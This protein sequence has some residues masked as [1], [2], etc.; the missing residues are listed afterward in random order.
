MYCFISDCLIILLNVVINITVIRT[1]SYYD[2][3]DGKNEEDTNY[4]QVPTEAIY[5][6]EQEPETYDDV[7]IPEVLEEE[8]INMGEE[9]T[10]VKESKELK[11]E[12]KFP[13]GATKKS[14]T[15]VQVNLDQLVEKVRERL[16]G[17]GKGQK[18]VR[19]KQQ[20]KK[21]RM[22]AHGGTRKKKGS[23]TPN[24]KMINGR[25]R[26]EIIE[27]HDLYEKTSLHKSKKD[28]KD[29]YE[30]YVTPKKDANALISEE[31]VELTSPVNQVKI[32]KILR[33][34]VKKFRSLRPGQGRQTTRG[35]KLGVQR[36]S[37][38]RMVKKIFPKRKK[39][40]TYV[41]PEY[42]DDTP[43]PTTPQLKVRTE[44]IGQ[45]DYK[46]LSAESMAKLKA[47][48]ATATSKKAKI[49]TNMQTRAKF[50]FSSPNY[51]AKLPR[52]AEKYNFDEPIPQ[53]DQE[54]EKYKDIVNE[55][56]VLI[57]KKVQVNPQPTLPIVP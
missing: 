9:E 14:Q 26:S 19:L 1:Q 12:T 32:S 18:T 30:D 45:I 37:P 13:R 42:E 53:K 6:N 54:E 34:P 10:D 11:V 28:K 3:E 2:P 50:S 56:D 15:P 57:N 47:K 17:N 39:K 36:P 25:A 29:S 21:T 49:V 7:E 55:P 43:S 35:Q 33:Q 5:N 46:D 52:I 22:V 20:L 40:T 41:A 23:Q 4:Y 31:Q 38:K 48:D 16:L 8:N 27:Q 44:I 51:Y 24:K